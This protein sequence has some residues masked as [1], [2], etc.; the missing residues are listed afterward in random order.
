[1]S[2]ETYKE[3][4]IFIRNLEGAKYAEEIKRRIIERARASR[5]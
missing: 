3:G 2:E 1:M 4:D 5:S